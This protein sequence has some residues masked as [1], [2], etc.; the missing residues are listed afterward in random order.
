MQIFVNLVKPG[1]SKIELSTENKSRCKT[2]FYSIQPTET[3]M[4]KYE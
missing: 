3:F 2:T 1:F 4:E